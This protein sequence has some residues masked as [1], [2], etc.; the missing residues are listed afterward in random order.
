MT[1]CIFRIAALALLLPFATIA[2]AQRPARPAPAAA[3]ATNPA[4]DPKLFS[5]PNATSSRLKALKWRNVGPFRGGRVVAVAGDPVKQFTAYFGA[6]NGG[7]WRTANGGQTWTN[8]TDGKTDIS[9]V[10]AIAVAPS[11]PNVIYVGTGEA[12]LREDLT[13]GTG[14]YRS[15]DKGASWIRINDA[16]HQF[17]GVGNGQLVRGDWNVFGR[18]YMSSAGRGLIYGERGGTNSV[19]AR[20][21]R[22]TSLRRE[23]MFVTGNALDEIRL[24]DLRGRL[25]RRSQVVAGVSRLDLSGLAHGIFVARTASEVLAVE[26]AR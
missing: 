21:P 12:Q 14:M 11:D 10:G 9:S 2:S 1:T 18:V 25:V 3:V 13:Y 5:D 23:G 8:L 15:T 4:Y 17:G 16:A 20:I 19:D 24:V 22:S 26:T 6:V 7:V